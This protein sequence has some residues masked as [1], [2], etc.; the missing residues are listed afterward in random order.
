MNYHI[1]NLLIYQEF[2][3]KNECPLCQIRKII[4]DRLINQYLNEKVM[5]PTCRKIVNAKGFCLQHQK[6][7]HSRESKLSLALQNSTRMETVIS[8]MKSM[9]DKKQILAQ[10]ELL[11]KQTQTCAIC[12][13]VEDTMTRYAMTVAQ[14][15]YAEEKFKGIL[16][17]TKGFCMYHYAQLLKHSD[18]AKSKQVEFANLIYE[19][20]K[21][22]M[23]KS[24]ADL[25]WFCDKNDHKNINAPWRGCE[26]ALARSIERLQIDELKK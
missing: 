4:E 14:M 8:S 18:C 23:E 9:K 3:D 21:A 19:L 1:G 25:L 22:N 5:E 11:E 16:L 20:Q 17:G 24:I 10:A 2:N 12:D 26:N 15:Y 13:D 7:M 6:I